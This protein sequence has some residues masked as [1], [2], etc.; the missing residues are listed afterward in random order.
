M[1]ERG[2][3]GPRRL[4]YDLEAG[5]GGASITQTG[6]ACL[7]ARAEQIFRGTLAAFQT[8]VQRQNQES[9]VYTHG[10]VPYTVPPR[11]NRI[12]EAWKVGKKVAVAAW[13]VVTALSKLGSGGGGGVEEEERWLLPRRECRTPVRKPHQASKHGC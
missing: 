2:G 13:R 11:Q 4:E 6:P 7:S 3:G 10:Y 1:L 5:G 9:G 12:P 8:A